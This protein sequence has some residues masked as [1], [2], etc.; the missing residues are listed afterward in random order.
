MNSLLFGHV[1]TGTA[2][3]ILGR[4]R[5][6]DINGVVQLEAIEPKAQQYLKSLKP[7]HLQLTKTSDTYDTVDLSIE[8]DAERTTLDDVKTKLGKGFPLNDKF[9]DFAQD[10]FLTLEQFAEH[11]QKQNLIAF[12]N[13]S[14][15][16][17]EQ[18]WHR[19]EKTDV[20]GLKSYLSSGSWLRANSTNASPPPKENYYGHL[21]DA[22]PTP[23]HLDFDLYQANIPESDKIQ[24]P[25][26]SLSIW[27]GD[28]HANPLIHVKPVTKPNDF[29]MSMIINVA[30][31]AP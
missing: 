28:Q 11:T 25:E 15:P 27:K 10:V 3:E 4:I 13:V 18:V 20:R 6:P 30:P 21:G 12:F 14:R 1:V 29:R 19:D 8:F 22:P 23:P 16:D 9:N 5:D 7:D 26:A 2:P 17:N 24:S 31:K